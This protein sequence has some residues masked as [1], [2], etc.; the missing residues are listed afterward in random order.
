MAT[1]NQ[2]RAILTSQIGGS[3][4]ATDARLAAAHSTVN[5]YDTRKN[6]LLF[7]LKE[8][9]EEADPAT[10]NAVSELAAK[11]DILSARIQSE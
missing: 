4:E 5:E 8:S 7:I 2:L 3:L 9:D 1:N 6:D 10:A 11:T